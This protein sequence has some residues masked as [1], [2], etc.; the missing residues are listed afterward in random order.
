MTENF[1]PLPEPLIGIS[2]Q[3]P[4]MQP[5]GRGTYLVIN[6]EYCRGLMVKGNKFS[7][8]SI[9]SVAVLNSLPGIQY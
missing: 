2:H 3:A 9:G 7:I 4:R 1:S 5:S 8:Y 6:F